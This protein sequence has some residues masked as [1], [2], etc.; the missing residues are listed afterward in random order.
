MRTRHAYGTA[1]ELLV[2]ALDS[3]ADDPDATP[4]DRYRLLME[5][6]DAHRWQGDWIGAARDARRRRSRSPTELDDV[7]LLARAA[8]SMTMGALWQSPAHGADHPVVIAALRRCPGGAAATTS[9]S[10]AA[11]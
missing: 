5:L 7:R 6:A 1:A 2:A 8:S 3:L 11:G 9:G 10:C 4:A